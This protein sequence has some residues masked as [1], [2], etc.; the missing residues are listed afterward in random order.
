MHI[1]RKL[2]EYSL[3]NGSMKTMFILTIFEILRF[4]GRS[5]LEPAQP[6]PGSK[7][8]KGYTGPGICLSHPVKTT[9]K[10]L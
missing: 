6:V 4:E 3:K 2:V 8:V 10:S 5:L 9:V 7:R 1:I